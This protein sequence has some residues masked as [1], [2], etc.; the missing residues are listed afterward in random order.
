VS[1]HGEVAPQAARTVD[2]FLDATADAPSALVIEGEPGI[3]KTTLWLTA[4]ERARHRGFAVLSARGAATESVLAYSALADIFQD[5][6]TDSIPLPEPQRLAVDRIILGDNTTGDPTDPRTV[7]AGLVSVVSILAEQSP[8]LI[9]LDDLQWLDPASTHAFGFVARRLVGRVGLLGTFRTESHRDHSPSWFAPP[10]PDKLARIRL[11]PLSTGALHSVLAHRLG[12]PLTRPQMLRINDVSGGNPFYA[13]ELARTL[14]DR[15]GDTQMS[16]P[17]TLMELVR[18]RIGT[19]DPPAREAL[20]A[21]SCLGP[22]NVSDVAAAT[23]TEHDVVQ[24]LEAAE[25]LGIVE[26]SGNRVSFTHP[27]LARGCYDD[28]SPARRRAMHRRLAELVTEPELRARHLALCD[29]SGERRTLDALDEAADIAHRRGAPATAAELLGLAIGLGADTP[30]RRFRCAAFHFNAGNAA[31]ARTMLERIISEGAPAGPPTQ[32]AHA[33]RLLGLWSM[34]D[35]SSRHAADLLESA[36]ADAGDDPTLRAQILIP[37]AFAQINVD[38]PDR[39]ARY[40]EAAVEAATRC[41]R[42]QILSQALSMRALVHFLIGRGVDESGLQRALEL[43]DSQ[44]PISALLGPTVHHAQ[45]LVGTGQLDRARQELQT[46]RQRYIERGEESELI[47]VAFHSGLGEIWR[48]DFAEAAVI[49]EDA[50]QRAVLLGGDGLPLSVAL[51]LR[52][53]VAAHTGHVEQ[54][55]ADA[56]A[57]LTICRRCDSPRLV[58]VWPIATLGFVEVSLGDHQAAVSHLEPLLDA[59]TA[60]PDAT[61]IFTAGFL[62]DAAEALIGLGRL[63]DA[64]LLVDALE[65]NGR[66]LDRPWMLATGARGRTMLLAQRG[67]LAAAAAAAERAMTEHDRLPMPFE[68]ART[69][70]ILG[71]LQRRQRRRDAAT[72]TMQEALNAFEQLDAPLWADRVRALLVHTDA[73]PAS[74]NVLTAGERRV[75]ELTASGMTNRE[76]AAALFISPKTVEVH[77][78]RVYRKLNVRTRAELARRLDHLEA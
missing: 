40:I 43:E 31:E 47:I 32:R 74:A 73:D 25:A 33:R 35:A 56:T 62:P 24:S 36:L 27:L 8:V 63:V 69:Q 12:R 15:P 6:G 14:L 23:G 4:I 18:S 34:L 52:A 28:V 19:L 3:G 46:V 13:I 5:A 75:A 29:T 70:L 55:R 37:L 53:M 76:V 50:M 7:G 68:R 26:I 72:A 48:G 30:E 39:A 60:A 59:I 71:Q 65:R 21:L 49:A 16:M 66:R 78:T 9:A 64:E 61:E 57:A 44:A 77:L 58:T 1:A 45:L 22:S 67:D 2:D 17:S 42:A 51:M 20:L 38:E 11:G 41:E 10:A 54:A